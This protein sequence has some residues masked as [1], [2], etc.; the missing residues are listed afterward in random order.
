MHRAWCV[1]IT[2]IRSLMNNPDSIDGSRYEHYDSVP[3]SSTVGT[4]SASINKIK[5]LALC[6]IKP[7]NAAEGGVVLTDSDGTILVKS[8]GKPIVAAELG[9]FLRPNGTISVSSTGEVL[10]HSTT[11]PLE[12]ASTQMDFSPRDQ[13]GPDSSIAELRPNEIVELFRASNHRQPAERNISPVQPN[14]SDG[15]KYVTGQDFV[16]AHFTDGNVVIWLRDGT[17]IHV[18]PDAMLQTIFGKGVVLQYSRKRF[19]TVMKNNNLPEALKKDGMSLCEIPE[20]RVIIQHTCRSIQI[21]LPNG[22][23]VRLDSGGSIVLQNLGAI[24]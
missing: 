11:A 16:R 21:T 7:L 5:V 4:T 1:R 13:K 20:E 19:L 9:A 24:S 6:N 15:T 18:E 14:F 3:C 17:R 8:N 10:S 22:T 23:I 2:R 12:N